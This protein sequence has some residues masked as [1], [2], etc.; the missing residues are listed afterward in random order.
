MT[1]RNPFLMYLIALTLS[2]CNSSNKEV[3]IGLVHFEND[4]TTILDFYDKPGDTGTPVFSVN[5]I[6]DSTRVAIKSSL[7]KHD[8]LEFNPFYASSGRGML[9]LQVMERKEGW[10]R[11][12]SDDIKGIEHW[13]ELSDIKVERWT[14]FLLSLY[15]VRP[16]N[17]SGNPLRKS[18]DKRASSLGVS[19]SATCLSV[20]GVQ[21]DWIKVVNELDRCPDEYVIE[22]TFEG[23]LRWKRGGEILIN[24]ML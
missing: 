15:R 6:Y 3:G 16:Y 4:F 1:L 8:T 21:G 10:L 17:A 14:D 7:G 22:S 9:I 24:F 23:F 2:S 20:V 18:P 12:I 13:V 19:P 11:I 5:L